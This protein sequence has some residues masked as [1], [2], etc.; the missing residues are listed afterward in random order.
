MIQ[1]VFI[2]IGVVFLVRLFA[3]QV[4]DDTYRIKAERNIV[5]RIVEYPFRGLIYD[6]EQNLIVYNEPIYDLMVVPRD[7]YIADT[8]AFCD[9][10]AIDKESFEENVKS[11]KYSTVKPSPFIQKISHGNMP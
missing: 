1:A 2:L 8:A 7:V 11:R 6:R 10:F 4:V 5:Q 9:L 3:L